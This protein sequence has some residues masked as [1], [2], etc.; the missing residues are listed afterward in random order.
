MTSELFRSPTP[1]E[2]E[3]ARLQVELD[4]RRNELE[5]LEGER[6]VLEV[7]LTRFAAEVKARI[8]DVKD[9]IRRIR[10]ELETVRQR[11]AKLRADPLATPADV[12]RDVEE[13]M[14]QA[15]EEMNGEFIH[16]PN[17]A[18]NRNLPTRPMSSI[19]TEAEVLRL[20]RELAKRHHPDLARS[21]EERE[22][23]AE[24]MLRV[25]V[26][27]RD[28][29]LATLQSIYLEVQLDS[30]LS[31][32]ELCRQRL[33]WTRHEIARLDREI[34]AVA[35]R[36][37]ALTNT[38]TYTLWQAQERGETALD[39]LEQRTRERL[40]RE[41]ERLDEATAQYDRLAVRRQV[42]QRRAASRA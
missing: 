21:P 33:S 35:M 16:G 42:M 34:R 15:D 5:R 2:I 36:M 6:D 12:E 17:G 41:R 22:R 31:P 23:R 29:D 19:E 11:I 10:H 27:Y 3:L 39:D 14:A 4:Y 32:E 9:E 18:G 13:E 30:P 25:N 40:G 24:L 1:D 20:Y 37:D 7:G 38:D 28:R 8:G 26:A